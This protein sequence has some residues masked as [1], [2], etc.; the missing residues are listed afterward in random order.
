MF[1]R[2][3]R[4]KREK[5]EEDASAVVVAKGRYYAGLRHAS[6]EA[7]LE[8]AALQA[9][10]FQRRSFKDI[11]E[12][13]YWLAQDRL[14]YHSGVQISAAKEVLI[15]GGGR[16]DRQIDGDVFPDGPLRVTVAEQPIR[17]IGGAL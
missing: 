14:P 8:K 10:I 17:I 7:R 12:Y 6:Y 9:C 16:G 13:I 1:N 15:Q 2:E 5:V 11:F 3:K 4:E